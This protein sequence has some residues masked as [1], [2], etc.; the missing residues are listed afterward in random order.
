MLRIFQIA[1]GL[2]ESCVELWFLDW[3][4][5]KDCFQHHSLLPAICSEGCFFFQLRNAAN[6][7]PL[8]LGAGR[9]SF[10][11]AVAEGNSLQ[12]LNVPGRGKSRTKPDNRHR[13]AEGCS[14]NSVQL[15]SEYPSV[16]GWATQLKE[17]VLS[18]CERQDLEYCAYSSPSLVLAEQDAAHG[19]ARGW[20]LG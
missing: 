20:V 3:I 13:R 18:M 2:L 19:E 8:P 9:K 17:L 12:L 11:P 6:L 14:V 5:L 10:S 16:L 7:A 15:R 4:A 1:W